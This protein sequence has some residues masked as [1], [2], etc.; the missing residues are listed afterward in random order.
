MNLKDQASIPLGKTAKRLDGQKFGLLTALRPVGRQGA[1]VIWLCSCTC[2]GHK[3][4]IAAQLRAKVRSCGCLLTSPVAST[5]VGPR[6]PRE[7]RVNTPRLSPVEKQRIAAE[8]K[9]ARLAKK[10]AENLELANSRAASRIRSAENAG[11]LG[12]EVLDEISQLPPAD[13]PA[14]LSRATA[15]EHNR[16]KQSAYD[17]KIKHNPGFAAKESEKALRRAERR[18]EKKA[19]EEAERVARNTAYE[20]NK[21][22]RATNSLAKYLAVADTERQTLREWFFGH[23][24]PNLHYVQELKDVYAAVEKLKAEGPRM[25][26]YD[27]DWI[28]WVITRT[29][30]PVQPAWYAALI[31]L[32]NTSMTIPQHVAWIND[33]NYGDYYENE[34]RD[35]RERT[36]HS[37]TA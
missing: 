5:F 20:T 10:A 36:Y 8:K 1:N 35:Y 37:A 21:A 29:N 17:Y 34:K 11:V 13:I 24:Y 15:H 6:Q 2:G 26:Q 23:T 25:Q 14:A 33:F 18:E 16:V 22:E 27:D 4:V 19:Q 30:K 7:K 28:E 9:A 31:E 32:W 3:N 12:E